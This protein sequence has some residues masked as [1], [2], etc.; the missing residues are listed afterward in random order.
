MTPKEKR[1][2]AKYAALP[3]NQEAVR[4]AS[5]VKSKRVKDSPT[6][7]APAFDFR[8]WEFLVAAAVVVATFVWTFGATIVELGQI[9]EQEPDYSHGF[10][11]FPI[12]LLLLWMRMDRF[13]GGA[14]VPGWSGLVLIGAGLAVAV[15]GQRFFLAPLAG[16]AM[17]IWFAGAFW[18][19]AGRRVFVWAL[20][21][22]VFLLFMVPL[23]FR[24]EQ[25]MSWRLQRIA[26][27]A[28]TWMLQL[29]GQPAIAEG[30][31]VYLGEQVLE[32]EQ[33]CSGL[34]MF[35]GIAALAFAF[36]VATRRP[37]WEKLL[38]ILS[39]APLAMFAN[40]VR[41]AGTG[42]LLQLVSSEAA[43]EFSHNAAGW[44]MIVFATICLG[45]FV[46]WLR[47]VV[48]EVEVETGR[49]LISHTKTV[50]PGARLHT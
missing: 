26:T 15:A 40:S 48:Q 42:L 14:G 1:R 21:A 9:W 2:R 37:W 39:V 47:W 31:I 33:A 10:L 28:S 4:A 24:V 7:S 25:M 6:A 30:N 46:L 18:L 49:T 20:P 12:A 34:R 8:S 50:A 27:V 11:V 35:M 16:W 41:V 17:V 23:P 13:P 36:A 32:V 19:L 44:A 43:A 22:I 5:A 38:L 3:G 45:L 29:V